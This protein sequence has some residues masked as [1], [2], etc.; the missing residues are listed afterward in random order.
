[1][2]YEK[3]ASTL[4][5]FKIEVSF[6]KHSSSISGVDNI[7]AGFTYKDSIDRSLHLGPSLIASISNSLDKKIKFNSWLIFSNDKVD[8]VFYKEILSFA[9]LKDSQKIIKLKDCLD[10][11]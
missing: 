4:D 8:P 2:D 11:K 7:C 5:K 10:K 3:F 1:M 6:T 9:L